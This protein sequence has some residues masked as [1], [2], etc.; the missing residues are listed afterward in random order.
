MIRRTIP[1]VHGNYLGK[2]EL[3]DGVFIHPGGWA[4]EGP[5]MNVSDIT[6]ALTRWVKASYANAIGEDEHHIVYQCG[7]CRF[8]LALDGDYGICA[9]AA[10]PQD[11]RIIFEHGGCKQHSEAPHDTEEV[12]RG[13]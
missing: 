11:G 4:P 7:G 2:V 3:F 13:H 8:M 12:N 9:N 6:T 10:S 5:W 1:T